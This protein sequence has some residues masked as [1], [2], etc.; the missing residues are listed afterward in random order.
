[1]NPTNQGVPMSHSWNQ[2][3]SRYAPRKATRENKRTAELVRS[4]GD[5]NVSVYRP[6]GQRPKTKP[7]RLRWGHR[8][9]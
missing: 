4:L 9:G 3:Q 8:S 1:M 5:V 6:E 2:N 7:V